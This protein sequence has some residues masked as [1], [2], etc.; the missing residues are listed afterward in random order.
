MDIKKQLGHEY[1]FLPACMNTKKKEPLKGKGVYWAIWRSRQ[2][3][4]QMKSRTILFSQ[5][6]ARRLVNI[7]I[8]SM[9]GSIFKMGSCFHFDQI[10]VKILL[11]IVENPQ[12]LS[13]YTT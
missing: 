9:L 1:L 6:S 13:E 2:M 11:L 7:V 3:K 12:D 5:F 8:H 4:S 10:L